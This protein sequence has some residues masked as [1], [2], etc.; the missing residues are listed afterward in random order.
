MPAFPSAATLLQLT[1][2][3]GYPFLVAVVLI[4]AAGAPLPISAV[5]LTL[6][7]L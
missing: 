1:A 4:A 2:I 5:L 6:G 7:A 3:Y